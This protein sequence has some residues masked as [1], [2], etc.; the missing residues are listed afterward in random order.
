MNKSKLLVIN[1]LIK[2][3]ALR[4]IFDLLI[5]KYGQSTVTVTRNLERTRIKIAK[6]K[7]DLKFL[8]T[9]KKHK[10]TPVFDVGLESFRDNVVA[11]REIVSRIKKLLLENVHK[12]REGEIIDRNTMRGVLTMMVEVGV[13]SL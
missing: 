3:Y 11:D 1:F 5:G 7:S 13:N 8:L 2:L 10:L 9:C 4:N 6:L 12:E